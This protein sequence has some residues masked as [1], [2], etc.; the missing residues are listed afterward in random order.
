MG[1]EVQRG[2]RRYTRS[3]KLNGRVVREYV[4][5]GLVG[6]LAAAADALRRAQRRAT[7]EA[8]H[9]EEAHW[10]AALAPLLEL[11]Q[12]SKLLTRS[13]MLVAGFHQHARGAWRRRRYGFAQ[14]PSTSPTT[15]KP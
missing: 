7:A 11:C 5:V 13:V 14:D 15:A 8:R 3:R 4:G 12:V 2:R 10:R 1:W 6:E 9:A